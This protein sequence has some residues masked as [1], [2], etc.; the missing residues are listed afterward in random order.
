MIAQSSEMKKMSPMILIMFK[1]EPSISSIKFDFCN[2]E[3]NLFSILCLI[4]RFNSGNLLLLQSARFN[5]THSEE[6]EYVKVECS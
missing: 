5:L 1:A 3:N 2:F 6:Y 4:K